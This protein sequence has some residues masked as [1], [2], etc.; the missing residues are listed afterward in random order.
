MTRLYPVIEERV[1]RLSAGSLL[2]VCLFAVVPS[3]AVG[4]LFGLFALWGYNTVGWGTQ[5]W[6]GLNGLL[7]GSLLGVVGGVVIALANFVLVWLGMV[8]V[9]TFKTTKIRFQGDRVRGR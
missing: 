8:T 2:K 5:S 6:V 7:L 3:F 9:A 1:R 4:V